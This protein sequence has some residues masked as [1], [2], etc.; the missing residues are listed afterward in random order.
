MRCLIE[1]KSPLPAFTKGG[2]VR[3]SLFKGGGAAPCPPLVTLPPAPQM[4][5]TGTIKY[6][7]ARGNES[8]I[9]RRGKNKP[10]PPSSIYPLNMKGG[11]TI[12]PEGFVEQIHPSTFTRR[13]AAFTLAEVLITLGII[14]IVAAMTLPSI[15]QKQNQ[16]EATSRLKKFYSVMSQA[17]MLSEVDNGPVQY[18]DKSEMIR[19]EDGSYNSAENDKII[20]A[21]YD[22]YLAKYLKI[23]S[24]G[25]LREDS[26]FR[27]YT[28]FPD[29]SMAWYGNGSCIDIIYDYNGGKNPNLLG[30][31]R[32][33]FLLC[34]DRK[35]V[36]AG[37]NLNVAKESRTEAIE[38]C[39]T[40]PQ[41]C[42]GILQLDNW[43]FK[44]DYSWPTVKKSTY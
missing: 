22:K 13:K 37:F 26:R 38:T 39:K 28:K 30:Y 42:T 36:F 6:V 19:D 9:S 33:S 16:K 40:K 3:T 35:P 4:A 24:R 8:W 5:G 41:T 14:G 31:D 34:K 15:I 32:F 18:W 10:L 12:V 2:N 11:G 21:F 29:G 17:I 44:P 1:I 20:E 25:Y 43:E 23:T 7:F 27:F